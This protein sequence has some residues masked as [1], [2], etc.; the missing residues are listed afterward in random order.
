MLCL[1]AQYYPG[2]KMHLVCR[3]CRG[4]SEYYLNRFRCPL[5]KKNLLDY[6][7]AGLEHE[8][9]EFRYLHDTWL[10]VKGFNMPTTGIKKLDSLL[11]NLF[12]KP[13]A[14]DWRNYAKFPVRETS[15]FVILRTVNIGRVDESPESPLH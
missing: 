7:K 3:A 1:L 8:A 12:G 10:K 15:K 11:E 5:C 2:S 6:K 13:H 4:N 9:K 14:N